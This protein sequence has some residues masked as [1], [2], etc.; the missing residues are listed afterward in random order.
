[1]NQQEKA[2]ENKEQKH[3]MEEKDIIVEV[4]VSSPM[5]EEQKMTLKKLRE[6]AEVRLIRVKD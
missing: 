6:F 3:P 5:T 4:E 1:M 2:M